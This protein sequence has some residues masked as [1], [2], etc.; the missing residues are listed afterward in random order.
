MKM[1]SSDSITKEAVEQM[2]NSAVINASLNARQMTDALERKHDKKIRFL[3]KMLT[4]SFA[5]NVMLAAG[6]YFIKL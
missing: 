5:V 3:Q 6:A 2:I 1:Y 4:A